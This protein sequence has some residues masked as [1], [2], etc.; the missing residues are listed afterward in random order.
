MMMIHPPLYCSF[1]A[2]FGS[3]NISGC[4]YGWNGLGNG[5][6]PKDYKPF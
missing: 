5:V 6:V 3:T 1:A 4:G 2:C